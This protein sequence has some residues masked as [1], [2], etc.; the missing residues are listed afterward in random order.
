MCGI[1][2][3]FCL[4]NT[5]VTALNVSLERMSR[6]LRLR[7]PDDE[8]FYL[9]GAY[10]Q[11]FSGNSTHPKLASTRTHI[12]QAN[13]P[14]EIGL[15][16]RRLSIIDLSFESHQPMLS[17]NDRFVIS[18]NGE[19]YN[20]RAL[21]SFL[22]K[23]GVNLRTNGDT[24][25]LLELYVLLGSAALDMLNGDFAFAIWD[26]QEKSLFCARD[27]VGI[28][29]F[30]YVKENERFLFASDIKTLI[31]SGLYRPKVNAEGL[32]LAFAFGMSPR[33]ITAFDSVKALEPGTWM[34]VFSTGEIKVNRYWNI[35]VGTQNNGMSESGALELIESE[36]SKAVKLRIH[37]DV[38]VG[39]FMSGGID[40]TLVAAL[41]ASHKA[42]V[43]AFTL[44][45]SKGS[46][47][48]D[49]VEEASVIGG[50]IGIPHYVKR[51]DPREYLDEI[52]RI[53]FGYEEP[54]Y[55]VSPNYMVSKFV[56]DKGVKVAL[57]GLGGDELFAGYD[58]YKWCKIWERFKS[59]RGIVKLGCLVPNKRVKRIC[60]YL[61]SDSATLLHSSLF[62][63]LTKLD[64]LN[65]F[66]SEGTM[67]MDPVSFVDE[68]Y[69]NNISC[70]S[71]AEGLSYMDLRNYIGNHHVERA[72]QFTM[73]NSIEG[74]FPFL[75]HNLIEA[76]YSIPAHLKLKGNER[77]Y[78]LRKLSRRF[79]PPE[80][81]DMPKKGFSLPLSSWMNNELGDYVRE[82]IEELAQRGVFS[83]SVVNSWY[84]EYKQN[85][86]PYTD[87]WQLVS[88][89]VWLKEFFDS[90]RFGEQ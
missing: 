61:A 14:V 77:K 67:R 37:A 60:G 74:R 39:V 2:G 78:L 30:Y 87:V 79:L 5:N 27:R 6:Q 38:P 4:G 86:R 56:A 65:L 83:P 35:P 58:Y 70:S 24:E 66:Q 82:N 52:G 68:L 54:F 7:G 64:L 59:A 13:R 49:E 26:K 71:A 9:G 3:V 43:E 73:M 1:S 22:R 29:P 34:K 90:P 75:D 23:N 31:A 45:F 20:Y 28:K 55:S 81:L 46:C 63:K 51:V 32:M 15:V 80:S 85:K 76:A 47:I 48:E 11:N 69:A 36:L 72:D 89:N 17:S 21:A 88:T 10:E 33:P 40:S 18:F 19:I 50:Y 57:N 16:H 84:E 53:N 8:G 25:V 44:G 12:S 62:L 41:A 42:P